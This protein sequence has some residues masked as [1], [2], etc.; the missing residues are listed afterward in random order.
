MQ[1]AP[2]DTLFSLPDAFMYSQLVT[3][4]DENKNKFPDLR[5]SVYLLYWYKSTNT[6]AAGASG[7]RATSRSTR[8]CAQP[9]ICATGALNRGLRCLK[10]KLN[11]GL[12]E[13]K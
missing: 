6:D 9:S 5:Y 10:Q 13:A 12:I 7:R 3:F 2:I 1:F 11:R 8:T 4:V